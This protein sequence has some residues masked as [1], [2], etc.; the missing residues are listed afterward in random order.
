MLAFPLK[1]FLGSQEALGRMC[2]DQ[3]PPGW[4]TGVGVHQGR[5]IR[6]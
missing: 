5:E 4:D 2:C 6:A 3:V 1:L